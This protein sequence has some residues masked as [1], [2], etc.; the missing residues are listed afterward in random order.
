MNIENY[1][2]QPENNFTNIPRIQEKDFFKSRCLGKIKMER[3]R[4]GGS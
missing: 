3:T 1:V 4:A 2:N